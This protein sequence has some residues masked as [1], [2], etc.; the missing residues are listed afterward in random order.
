MSETI[1][2]D[3]NSAFEKIPML[4]LRGLTIF[5][6]ML[7]HFDVGREK[8]IK[9]LE[10]CMAGSRRIFLLAQKDA[11][12]DDPRRDDLYTVGT[13]C[14]IKQVLRLPNESTVR[15]MVEGVC[16]AKLL[17]IEQESPCFHTVVE[18]I[19]PPESRKNTPT[20]EALIRYCC[21]LFEQYVNLAPK[22]T[23]EVLENVLASTDAGYIS[24]YIAQN[25]LIRHAEKQ[26]V[27]EE[28]QPIKR[29]KMVQKILKRENEILVLE[30]GIAEKV[31]DQMNRN[32]K[33]YVLR[34]QLKVIQRELGEGDDTFEEQDKYKANIEKLGA[35]QDV[36]DKLLKELSRM[37]KQPFGSQEAAV[38]RNYLDICLDIPWDKS[39]KERISVE[40][41][42]KVLNGEHYGLEKV[43]ERILE[44]VAVRKLTP[45][46]PGQTICLVGPPG[47]G[48]TSIAMSI[49]KALNRKAVRVSLGGVRDESDIRGH[50]KTYVGAMPGRV[51][52]ALC[53]VGVNNPVM[54]L[55][56][57]DKMGSSHM[58]DPAAA[59]LEVLDTEQNH[60][61]RDHFVE[62]PV[63]LSR[64]MFIT[65]ANT[66]DTIPR[67]LLD[68]MEVIE[69]PSYTDEEKVQI[70]K[71][72]LIP[73]QVKKHG[74]KRG[75]LRITDDALREIIAGY[76]RES[77]VRVLEREIAKIC[78]RSAMK[79]V[80]GGEKTVTVRAGNLEEYL[81]VRRFTPEHIDNELE[82]GVVN[83]LA[84]T[85]VGGELLEVE[86]SVLPGTGKIELTG[87][88][89]DVMKESARTAVTC[90]RSRCDSLGID[91]NFYNT[92]D[93]HIHFPEGAVPKD[94]PSAGV[95]VTTA[96]VSALTGA[97][98]RRS[99]AMTGE[100]TLRGR[101]LPIGGL[102]EKTMAAMRNGIK[103]V[104]IPA[105][106]EKDLKEIDP[107]VRNALNFVT[108]TDVD[109]VIK[110]AVDF[111]GFKPFR[112]EE[113]TQSESY[114]IPEPKAEPSRIRQ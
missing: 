81:D 9:A 49:A 21:E 44:T 25:I 19:A 59:L 67:A 99:V 95:S 2:T 20:T 86:C 107:L 38:L 7:M 62:V 23:P 13:I 110:E 22:P 100:V 79:F 97:P 24:D 3:T 6:R 26:G 75:K 78:R 69:L 33:D 29:L 28:L 108:V 54:V 5:P 18:R 57:I 77:G 16:R 52:N 34:E 101:V 96:I 76:T 42:E 8:S 37:A 55:D 111:S 103:T 53:Q 17:T 105:D 11:R 10:E 71:R 63:D 64:V 14:I 56:E 66:A 15:V 93:I 32:Q 102:R 31:Q 12:T 60:A 46:V 58:G 48:K 89:G 45:D 68:R 109:K 41:T 65:T 104:I 43:K 70:A 35:S 50:R 83:G 4:A 88:L 90:I 91:P 72:H 85:S 98:V 36:K 114:V 94:G 74:I 47:V 82:V 51:I 1:I 87:N 40:A 92:K 113:K 39:T 106:N 73:K 27:L 84:W 30:Q 61:F 80:S 112:V